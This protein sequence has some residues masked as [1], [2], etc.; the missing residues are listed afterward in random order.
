MFKHLRIVVFLI[1]LFTSLLSAQQSLVGRFGF[2]IGYNS[3]VEFSNFSSFNEH[4]VPSGEKGLKENFLI[5]GFN[6]YLYFLIIPDTRLAFM[7]MNGN[8]SFRSSSDPNLYFEYQQSLWG[9]SL[10]YTFTLSNLNIS[11]GL[12]FGKVNDLFEIKNYNGIDVFDDVYRDYNSN[13]LNSKSISFEN[14]SLQLSPII[15]VEY[16]LT[17]F[18]SFRLNYI[19]LIRLNEDWRFLK[20]FTINNVPD[21][22]LVNSYLLSLGLTV[23]FMS[24]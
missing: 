3:G 6:S 7:Y 19:Y 20:K 21:N 8:S 4:F 15:N 1:L 16:S 2:G 13:T 22:F 11:S 14:S 23:G 9:F 18:L 10:E 12:I 24:K 5:S 17:R